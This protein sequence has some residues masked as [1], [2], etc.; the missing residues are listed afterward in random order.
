MQQTTRGVEWTTAGALQHISEQG[1]EA[2]QPLATK[3]ILREGRNREVR[4]LFEHFGL[5]ISQSR[6]RFG[7][8]RTCPPASSA[9]SF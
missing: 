1:G 9:A 5:T 7:S 3:V 2:R 8:L 4:R 6:V